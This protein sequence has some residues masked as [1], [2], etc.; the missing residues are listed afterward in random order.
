[1][2]RRLLLSFRFSKCFETHDHR[3]SW[4]DD[5]NVF[6]VSL[7]EQASIE[8]REFHH[9]TFLLSSKLYSY[10]DN[11]AQS[12]TLSYDDNNSRTSDFVSLLDT[13]HHEWSKI[14]KV[15]WLRESR[16]KCD[17]RHEIDEEYLFFASSSWCEEEKKVSRRELR[18]GRNNV[19]TC[20]SRTSLK[21]RSHNFESR[22]C[23]RD[24]VKL[25]LE[26]HL[27]KKM[28]WDDSKCSKSSKFEQLEQLEHQSNI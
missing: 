28:N 9:L 5:V 22:L 23:S 19:T 18:E 10:L 11:Q 25:R 8:V 15:A 21:Q 12:H 27:N 14:D 16:K 7:C 3:D 2:T 26:H 13:S 4:G 20:V 6:V 1:M 24:F 17:R